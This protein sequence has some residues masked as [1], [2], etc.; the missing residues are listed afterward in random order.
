MLP[1]VTLAERTYV[2][3]YVHICAAHLLEI[4]LHTRAVRRAP[5]KAQTFISHSLSPA[6]SGSAE[7]C[8]RCCRR[9]TVFAIRTRRP[10]ANNPR[11][12]YVELSCPVMP[13]RI[14]P[15]SADGKYALP[16]V[17]SLGARRHR[18]RFNFA[19]ERRGMS[20]K[21]DACLRRGSRARTFRGALRASFVTL[22][23]GERRE[24]GWTVMSNDVVTIYLTAHKPGRG[25][26]WGW[27]GGSVR[28]IC[29]LRFVLP[30][31]ETA[32]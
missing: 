25:R 18:R 16:A 7:T 32:R 30:L 8:Q 9:L 6:A 20:R 27:K 26:G 14:V 23:R 15:A 2:C 31:T 13:R 11:A 4:A 5:S 21:S 17:A 22:R 28:E 10:P 29:E 3:T 1:R 19:E 24:G 12:I